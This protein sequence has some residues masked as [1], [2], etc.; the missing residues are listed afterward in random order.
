MKTTGGLRDEPEPAR[1]GQRLAR[2][3][4]DVSHLFLSR[5]PAVA[6][7][8]SDAQDDPHVETDRLA[9]GSVTPATAGAPAVDQDPLASL[10]CKSVDALEEG[11]RVI[12][13]KIPLEVG[14][15]VDLV[16]VDRHNQLVIID[17]E[18]AETDALLLRGL[19][20]VDWFAR[21][22]PI[23]RRMYPACG[24]DFASEPRVLLLAPSFS[25][26]ILRA[27]RRIPLRIGCVTFTVAPPLP[28][29]QMV[30]TH[31]WR[32]RPRTPD[33]Y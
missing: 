23:A 28:S 13:A 8:R 30:F 11:L 15:T 19:C 10:V 16:A 26:V 2:G 6:S 9:R 21:N 1:P 20:H 7:L 3:L 32:P 24:I 4:E 27:V 5:A 12:D 29:P 22:V 33:G 17:V 18:C 14:G 25:P 31:C